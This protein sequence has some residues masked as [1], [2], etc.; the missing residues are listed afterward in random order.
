MAESLP[1]I[2]VVVPIYNEQET[3]EEL[4]QRITATMEALG[5]PYEIVAVDDGSRDQSVPILLRIR[6]G[7]S[8]LRIVRLFRNFGQ[9]AALYAG[10]SA[11]RGQIVVMLDA[12]LQN[13]PEEIPKLVAAID[14]GHLMVNGWRENRQDGF[15]RK[16]ISRIVNTVIARFTTLRVHDCGCSLKAFHRDVT[17]R[18]CQFSHHSRYLPADMGWL[19]VPIAEVKVSHS[20]RSKGTSKYGALKLVRTGFDL[21]TSVT[22]LPIQA[23]GIL[24]WM[25]SSIGFFMGMLIGMKRIIWGNYDPFLT[26][27]A[28]FFLLMGVHMVAMGFVC[29]YIGRIYAE[30]QRKPYY[31][32]KEIIE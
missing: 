19:G 3:V 17:D 6:A 2:S 25:V 12:D 10:F 7:D 27:I 32:V 14:E 15:I 9:T 24:G 16:R 11:V 30:V 20:P 22:T 13:P 28:L 29:E 1:E 26:V 8:R 23:V 31:I 5:R 4:Y 21:L 18:L